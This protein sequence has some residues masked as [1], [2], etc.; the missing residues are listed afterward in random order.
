MLPD[1]H[2]LRCAAGIALA[3]AYGLAWRAAAERDVP[4]ADVMSIAFLFA[5]PL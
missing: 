2:P 5:V 1:A 3:T 4:G